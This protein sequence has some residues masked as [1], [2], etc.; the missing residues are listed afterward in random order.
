LEEDFSQEEIWATIRDLPL[1]KAP[2]LDE[3]TGRFY[4]SGWNFNEGDIKAAILAIQQGFHFKFRLLNTAFITLLPNKA[5][6]TQVKDFRPISLIH[7]F[8]KLVAKAMANRLAPVL[9]NPVSISQSTF[10]KG[11]NIHDNYLFVSNRWPKV[12]IVRKRLTFS[13]SWT[14]QRLLIRW[15]GPFSW[16]FTSSGL[17]LSLVQSSLPSTVNS[18]HS[19]L[20]QWGSRS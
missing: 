4:K 9:P 12:C 1:D 8:A 17:R 6:A 20:G 19:D 13:L 7:S 3:F 14:S 15:L 2:G 11:W 5:D 18:P 10:A 16:R